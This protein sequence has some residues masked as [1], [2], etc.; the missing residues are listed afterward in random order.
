MIS[1]ELEIGAALVLD[2]LLGDPWGFPHPVRLIGA[3]AD[4]LEAVSRRIIPD[5]RKAGVAVWFL[6]TAATGAA[7]LLIVRLAGTVHPLGRD[8]A[9]VLLLYFSFAGRDLAR[10]GLRVLDAL[11]KDDLPEA[12]RRLGMIVSRET[13]SMSRSEIV[14]STVES[15]AE[16]VSDGVIAPL[17]FAFLGGP[18]AAMAYKAVSTM[19]SM[20]GY[21]NDRYLR[22]GWFAARADDLFN[23]LP[24]RLTGLFFVLAAAVTG[25]RPGTAFT[26]LL[27]DAGK[28]DSPNA[29]YPEAAAAGALGIYLGGRTVYFGKSVEKPRIGTDLRE[30]EPRCISEAVLLMAV[31][32]V[33]FAAAGGGL[34]WGIPGFI[35]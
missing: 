26:T 19:D 27:R 17:F 32:V 13:G 5:E 11:K 1:L 22:F 21:K 35:R 30:A 34:R 25:R 33:L 23:Y 24:A 6:V 16:N 12:R 4:R 31:C 29:G 20:F 18:A 8:A 10:H 15:I 9:G 7:A 14:R 3:V 28:R 2:L